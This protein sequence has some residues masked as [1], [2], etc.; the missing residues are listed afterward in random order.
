M[1]VVRLGPMPSLAARQVVRL[2]AHCPIHH[3]SP[4]WM[5]L[6]MAEV[7]VRAALAEE[8]V[9]MDLAVTRR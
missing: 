3:P 7:V 9:P 4:E 1:E 8:N 2:T 6:A 5:G